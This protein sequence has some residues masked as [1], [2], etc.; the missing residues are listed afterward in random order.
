MAVWKMYHPSISWNRSLLSE[1]VGPLPTKLLSRRWA[2]DK[3]KYFLTVFE[4]FNYGVC[5]IVLPFS[6]ILCKIQRTICEKISISFDMTVMCDRKDLRQETVDSL[7][8]CW[9]KMCGKFPLNVGL[10]ETVATKGSHN[11]SLACP[12]CYLTLGQSVSGNT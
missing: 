7:Y 6:H 8:L 4:G 9:V 2:L 5:V 1:T 12:P 3:P 10:N 11:I